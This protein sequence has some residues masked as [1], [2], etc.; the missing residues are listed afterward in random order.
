MSIKVGSIGRNCELS[1]IL[2]QFI[3]L[4]PLEVGNTPRADLL[5]QRV[6]CIFLSGC[7]LTI[8]AREQQGLEEQ[9]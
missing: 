1:L 6:F 9:V 4:Y 2:A 3:D 5:L 7:L 8:Q